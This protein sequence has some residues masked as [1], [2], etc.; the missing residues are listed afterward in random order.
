MFHLHEPLE[1]RFQAL[2]GSTT[3]EISRMKEDISPRNVKLLSVSVTDTNET[4]SATVC[5]RQVIVFHVH[6]RTRAGYGRG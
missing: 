3:A 2:D 4:D 6:C 1:G 5:W